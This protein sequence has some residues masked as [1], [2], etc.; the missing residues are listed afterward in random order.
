MRQG[1]ELKMGVS[2]VDTANLLDQLAGNH[3]AL[4]AY[5][6]LATDRMGLNTSDLR[7]FCENA[8]AKGEA[9]WSEF[10]S[11]R[12]SRPEGTYQFWL[13]MREIIDGNLDPLPVSEGS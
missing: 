9:L 8:P 6:M 10:T 5:I 12:D 11:R 4:Q 13:F 7:R 3:Q 1:L 2:S